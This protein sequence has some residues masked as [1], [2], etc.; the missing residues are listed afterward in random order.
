MI[1][2]AS[3][4]GLYVPLYLTLAGG[5]GMVVN[6]SLWAQG[7]NVPI[8]GTVCGL[9]LCAALVVR[10]RLPRR[11][12][13]SDEKI[14]VV[15]HCGQETLVWSDVDLLLSKKDLKTRG[16]KTIPLVKVENK[17][18]DFNSFLVKGLTK[19]LAFETSWHLQ[20]WESDRSA[21]VETKKIRLI[22]FFAIFG[23]VSFTF[24]HSAFFDGDSVSP[25]TLF[26]MFMVILGAQLAESSVVG[27]DGVRKEKEFVPSSA[28]TG[29]SLKPD[30]HH[31]KLIVKHLKGTLELNKSLLE[32]VVLL[33]CLSQWNPR[34]PITG[35]FRTLTISKTEPDVSPALQTP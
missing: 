7:N 20:N 11:Y 26:P 18:N 12:E 34:T 32:A 15:R 29:L 35:E 25:S 16:G 24:L 8:L 9:L 13:V 21:D 3:P 22:L 30:G 6:L 31:C 4:P 14:T 2:E 5:L 23:M 28:I 27:P 1:F 10:L 33:Q 17:Q 19:Q